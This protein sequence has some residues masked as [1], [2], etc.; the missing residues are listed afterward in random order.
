MCF[1]A[2]VVVIAGEH[3][4]FVLLRADE[5]ERPR[6]DGLAADLVAAA[7]G[8]DAHGAVGEIPQQRGER[9]FEMEDDGVVVGHVDAVHESVNRCFCAAH[10]SLQQGVEG[11]LHVA[12]GQGAAVMKL[13]AVV[14]VEDVG[15]RIGNVPAFGQAG[16]DVKVVAAGEQ[17]V[18]DEIIDAFRLRV[19]AD[20]GIEV[21][22]TALDDHHQGVGIG[23]AGA[24]DE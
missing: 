22:G 23:F 10:L 2:P 7:V 5:T 1:F 4:I 6:A 17:V 20:A 12:S 8:N 13:D 14:Q 15:Q 11:P 9:F 21:G 3:N 19:Q 24:G 18:E 16:G